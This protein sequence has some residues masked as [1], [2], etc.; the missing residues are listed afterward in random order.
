M[1]IAREGELRT[2]LI[3]E[4]NQSRLCEKRTGADFLPQVNRVFQSVDMRVL[5]KNLIERERR[6]KDDGLY[7]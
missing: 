1:M 5:L 6:E 4:E 7:Y 2:H 3:Q